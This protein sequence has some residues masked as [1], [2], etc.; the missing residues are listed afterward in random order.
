MSKAKLTADYRRYVE[1]EARNAARL[2]NW[3]TPKKTLLRLHVGLLVRSYGDKMSYRPQDPDNALACLKSGIDGLRD[4]NVI[5]GD[6]WEYLAIEISG[7]R[8][9]PC[10]VLMTLI[11]L[12]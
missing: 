4:A 6:T 5:A 9:S 11:P 3:S 2:V 8:K 7:D 1:M 10:G 12:S